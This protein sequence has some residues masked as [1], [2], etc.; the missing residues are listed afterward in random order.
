MADSTDSRSAPDA[1]LQK[2]LAPVI[3]YGFSSGINLHKIV[4]D[5]NLEKQ[6][7]RAPNPIYRAAGFAA[8]TPAFAGTAGSGCD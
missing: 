3:R 7:T 8:A 1:V 6:Q 5:V 4:K 2:D